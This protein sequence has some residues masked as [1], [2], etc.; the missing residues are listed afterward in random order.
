MFQDDVYEVGK[1]KCDNKRIYLRLG[2]RVVANPS[3]RHAICDDQLLRDFIPRRDEAREWLW[4]TS[5]V[6][7]L[8][9]RQERV[10]IR[11][12]AREPAYE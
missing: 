4:K 8:S 3:M 9:N 6:G 10:S 2:Y 5:G 1:L 7:Q 12:L 11:Y